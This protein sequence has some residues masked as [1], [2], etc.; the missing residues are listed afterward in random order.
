MKYKI[1]KR[2]LMAAKE[3]LKL[4][5]DHAIEGWEVF[6]MAADEQGDVKNE[7][8]MDLY[9]RC[10]ADEPYGPENIKDA[11]VFI[12]EELDDVDWLPISI[13]EQ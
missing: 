2:D 1:R 11:Y 12:E 10:R 9:C 5:E 8:F 6:L 4:D 7:G 3:L 13:E